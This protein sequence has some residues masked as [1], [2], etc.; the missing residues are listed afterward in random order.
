LKTEEKTTPSPFLPFPP[1]LCLLLLVCVCPAK[2]EKNYKLRK[3]TLSHKNFAVY[4][5][6]TQSRI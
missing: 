2:L 4:M 3:H 6:H 5:A 1:M